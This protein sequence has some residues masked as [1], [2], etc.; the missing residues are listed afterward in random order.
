[1]ARLNC[2]PHTARV[3]LLA[4]VMAAFGLAS[5]PRALAQLPPRSYWKTLSGANA[6]PFLYLSMNGNANPID[7]AHTVVP[8][9]HVQAVMA[10]VGFLHTF[11]LFNR[12]ASVSA[13]EQMGH[14]S[15]EL[16]TLGKSYTATASGFGDPLAEFDI[17]VIGKKVIRNIP[18]LVRY[19]PGFAV[20]LLAD[21]VFPLGAY[22][23]SL[24]LNMGLNRW[25]GRVAAPVVWQLG[26]WVPGRRTTLE[27]VPSLWLFGPN[28][29]YLGHTLK[30]DPLLQVEGHLTRD[31]AKHLWGSL[32]ATWFTGGMASIDTVDGSSLNNWAIGYTLGYQVNKNIQATIAYMTT[33][34]MTDPGDLQMDGFRFSVV[35]GWHPLI[36]GIGR[37][38]GGD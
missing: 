33:I 8:G 12:S 23:D 35:F 18:D 25:Y 37:L 19:E 22:N 14:V 32:D 17:N 36:E 38:E 4:G 30:T 15:G 10:P 7:P 9:S 5:V 11:A 28:N 31:F 6:V 13:M 26:P 20:D 27:F 3:W 34:N 24:P 2:A 1:M 21:L 29:D 16:T